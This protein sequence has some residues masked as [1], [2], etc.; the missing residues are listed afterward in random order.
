MTRL[1][2]AIMTEYFKGYLND[3]ATFDNFNVNYNQFFAYAYYYT[4]GSDLLISPLFVKDNSTRIK[5]WF[6]KTYD[7]LTSEE[8]AQKQKKLTDS[9][10]HYY[11][12]MKRLIPPVVNLTNF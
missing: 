9:K 12:S 6:E 11:Q 5:S 10:L 2:K 1:D 4:T 3:H 7:Y 8:Y